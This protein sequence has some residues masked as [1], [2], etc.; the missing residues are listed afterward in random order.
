MV[1]APTGVVSFASFL[2]SH[3]WAWFRVPG[4]G[5]K[6]QGL[7]KNVVTNEVA[8]ASFKVTNAAGNIDL[9]KQEDADGTINE[10]GMR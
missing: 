8:E 7:N 10:N 1:S 5:L 6:C 2:A 4:L 3:R 9:R